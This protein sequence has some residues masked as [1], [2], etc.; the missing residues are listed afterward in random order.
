MVERVK[1]SS[2][3]LKPIVKKDDIEEPMTYKFL[4]ILLPNFISIFR[5]ILTVNF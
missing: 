4:N 2:E 5:P 1:L 3:L